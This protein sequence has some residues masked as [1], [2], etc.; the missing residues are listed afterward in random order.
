LRGEIGKIKVGR[1][2]RMKWQEKEWREEGKE[3]E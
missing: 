2:E 3:R 1:I